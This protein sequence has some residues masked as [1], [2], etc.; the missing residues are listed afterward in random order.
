MDLVPT[1]YGVYSIYM[2]HIENDSD[3][4]LVMVPMFR[5][6]GNIYYQPAVGMLYLQREEAGDLV[7]LLPGRAFDSSVVALGEQVGQPFAVVQLLN[8]ADHA[9]CSEGDECVYPGEEEC[10]GKLGGVGFQ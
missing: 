6:P 1:R 7:E 4:V 10:D 8:P 5:V 3:N 9:M 2:T